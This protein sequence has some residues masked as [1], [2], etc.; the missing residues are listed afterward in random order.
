MA[1]FSGE[2]GFAVVE[3]AV[4]DHSH[5]KAPAEVYRHHILVCV[6]AKVHVFAVGE[7]AGVVLYAHGHVELAL[8]EFLEGE[9]VCDEVGEGVALLGIHAAGKAH[10][11]GEDLDP[12]DALGNHGVLNHAAH[13]TERGSAGLKHEF[14]VFYVLEHVALEV[15]YG[16]VEMVASDV[17][18]HKVAGPGV[19]AVDTG[20]AT[21]RGAYLALVQYKAVVYQ[22]TYEFGDGGDA[23]SKRL[24]E[25]RD[26]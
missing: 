8:E 17:Y 21:A 10:A 4:Q 23:D 1:D 11:G 22:F 25:V 15:S 20:P 16:D 12:G 26:A 3:L 18:S 7:G 2:A 14:Y 9:V 13:L 6:L 24:A 19:E 5:A